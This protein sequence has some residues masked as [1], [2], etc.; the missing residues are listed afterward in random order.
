MKKLAAFFVLML[1]SA[2]YAPTTWEPC[3]QTNPIT[4]NICIAITQ[5][6][7]GIQSLIPVASMLM[8]VIAAVIYAAGQMMGAETRARANVWATAALTGALIGI[9]IVAI[10]P[11]VLRTIYSTSVNGNVCP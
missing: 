3:S 11:T 6:C 2:I 5:L 8:L 4:G 7:T 9:L 1:A 10:A